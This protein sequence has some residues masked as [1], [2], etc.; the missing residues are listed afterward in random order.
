LLGVCA[1]ARGKMQ[2]ENDDNGRSGSEYH[3]ERGEARSLPAI[4]NW[5]VD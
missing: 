2:K 3:V 4:E 5:T 1:D